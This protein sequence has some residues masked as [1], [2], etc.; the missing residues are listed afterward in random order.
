VRVVEPLDAEIGAEGAPDRGRED[1]EQVPEVRED[2][3]DG[4]ASGRAWP[5]PFAGVE[6]ADQPGY[7]ARVARI[8]AIPA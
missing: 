5:C 3:L 6:R 7:V 4:P 8:P 2:V 1:A